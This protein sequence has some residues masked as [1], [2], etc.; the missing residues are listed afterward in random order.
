M[1][2]DK[3]FNLIEH[4][5][6][7]ESR[8]WPCL[9]HD[10]SE[11]GKFWVHHVVPLTNRIDVRLKEDDPKKL[12]LRQDNRIN[13]NVEML[14]MRNY[15]VFYYLA[16]ACVIDLNDPYLFPE[17]VFFYLRA[18]TENAEKFIGKLRGPLTKELQLD[19]NVLPDWEKIKKD[20]TVEAIKE[21]RD[22][23]S[24]Y[25]RLGLRST[26]GEGFIPNYSV[27]KRARY[28]W[29]YV[30]QLRPDCFED[31]RLYLQKVRVDLMKVLNPIWKQV[32]KELDKRRTSE[33]YLQLYRLDLEGKILS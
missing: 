1:W 31:G 10:F 19:L 23:F 18:A 20:P 28:S 14:I 5:D 6:R 25:P 7:Y 15:S 32:N 22:A 21:Y 8:W 33:G 30:Q 29:K 13:D 2:W 11:W 26:L 12:F 3:K 24:H 9:E 27:L 4:G 16:R 17:D